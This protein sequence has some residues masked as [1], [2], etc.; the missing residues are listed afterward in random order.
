MSLLEQRSHRNLVQ[1][2]V[3]DYVVCDLRNVSVCA[4]TQAVHFEIP[5][6]IWKIRRQHSQG[7]DSA[8]SIGI[9]FLIDL[10]IGKISVA[11]SKPQYSCFRI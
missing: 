8:I 10:A 7:L 2:G 9:I 6:E 11:Y 3:G 1:T 4:P 5:E